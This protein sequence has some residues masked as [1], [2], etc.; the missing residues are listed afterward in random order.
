MSSAPSRVALRT[1][2]TT[3]SIPYQYVSTSP[4]S[5]GTNASFTR[6]SR[7]AASVIGVS[8]S[9]SFSVILDTA[10]WLTPMAAAMSRWRR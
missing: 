1:C 9:G 8:G 6:S 7:R 5:A 4:L 10:C 3:G 2:S